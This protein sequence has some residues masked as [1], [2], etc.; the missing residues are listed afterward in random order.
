MKDEE[1]KI[2]TDIK[3]VNFQPGLGV[4]AEKTNEV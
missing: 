2:T 1:S 4:R 3:S